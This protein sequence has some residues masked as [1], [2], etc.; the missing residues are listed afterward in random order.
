MTYDFTPSHDRHFDPLHPKHVA[1]LQRAL[2]ESLQLKFVTTGNWTCKH[3]TYEVTLLRCS[4]PGYGYTGYCKHLAL[5]RVLA[6]I[7]GLISPCP[8][9]D[10]LLIVYPPMSADEWYNLH[11]G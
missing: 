9:C 2:D 7:E 8:T 5:A 3:N 10:K 4:C 11:G 6:M 1:A